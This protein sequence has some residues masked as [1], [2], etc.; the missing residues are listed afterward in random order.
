[1]KKRLDKKELDLAMGHNIRIERVARKLSIQELADAI[2]LSATYLC[3]IEKG[4]RGATAVTLVML[5]EAFGIPCDSLIASPRAGGRSPYD[6][7]ETAT[8]YYLK[9]LQTMASGLTESE[10]EFIFDIIKRLAIFERKR[11]AAEKNKTHNTNR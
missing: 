4:Q 5:S 6:D 3:T 9:K 8:D 1:M 7:R 11:D 2:G 10:F